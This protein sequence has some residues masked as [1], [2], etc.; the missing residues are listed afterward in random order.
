MNISYIGQVSLL[1][2]ASVAASVIF[3]GKNN[4]L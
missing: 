3:N 4:Y 2:P 1:V